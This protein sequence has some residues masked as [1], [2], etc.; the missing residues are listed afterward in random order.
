MV[1]Y[2]LVRG[3][4]ELLASYIGIEGI[5]I[6]ALAAVVVGLYYLREAADLFVILARWARVGSLIGAVVL[7]LLVVGTASGVVEGDSLGSLAR[8]AIERISEVLH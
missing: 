2:E 1:V 4:L 5:A 6:G 7:V 3:F 8:Q